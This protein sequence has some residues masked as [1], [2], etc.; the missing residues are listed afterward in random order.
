MFWDEAQY[1]SF[2]GVTV[3]TPLNIVRQT[4]KRICLRLRVSESFDNPAI[5]RSWRVRP[6]NSTVLFWCDA[7]V[8]A[9]AKEYINAH[10]G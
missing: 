10:K 1:R 6:Q 7:G 4:P 2:E 9:P 8:Q 5:A 3:V